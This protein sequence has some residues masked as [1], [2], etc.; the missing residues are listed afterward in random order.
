MTENDSFGG[1]PLILERKVVSREGAGIRVTQLKMSQAWY[2]AMARAA[3]RGRERARKR[4][5][6]YQLKQF[7]SDLFSRTPKG[8]TGD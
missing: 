5:F 3:E 6:S 7:F 4:T 8:S 1:T 2:D